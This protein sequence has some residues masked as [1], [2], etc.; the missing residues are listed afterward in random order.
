MSMFN[1]ANLK[2]DSF[3]NTSKPHL[4]PYGI[5]KV[6]LTKIEKTELKGSKDPNAVYPVIALEFTGCGEDKGI[7]TTN[8]FIPTTKEDGVRPVYTNNEGH[9][10]ERPSRFENFQYTLMQI[11]QA[12]NPEGT[13]KIIANGEKLQDALNKDL[14]TGINLFIDLVIK[15]LAGKNKIETNIK[16]VGRNSN[17]TVYADLPR[18]CGLN[19]SGELFNTSFIGENLMFTNYEITQQKQY[20]SARP[21]NMDKVENNPDEEASD[22]NIDDIEL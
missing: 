11:V 18:A 7:F 3:V 2:E 10:Y 21:T 22:F 1:F 4:K 13:K 8:L 5:Y 14:T 16:L 6:N 17:G 12:L 15:A 9:E 20:Q 19:K